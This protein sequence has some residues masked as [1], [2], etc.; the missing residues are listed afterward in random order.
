MCLK[1][2]DDFVKSLGEQTNKKATKKKRKNSKIK[3][4]KELSVAGEFKGKRQSEHEKHVFPLSVCH[5]PQNSPCIFSPQ[6]NHSSPNAHSHP[7]PF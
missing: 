5:S 3:R 1:V 2:M 6:K 4:Y 7:L